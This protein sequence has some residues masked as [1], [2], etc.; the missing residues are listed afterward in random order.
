MVGA[1]VGVVALVAL[2][3]CGSDGATTS[4]TTGA[5]DRQA[6]STSTSSTPDETGTPGLP[7]DFV[8]AALFSAGDEVVA[9]APRGAGDPDADQGSED[10]GGAAAD[11][12]IVAYRSSDGETWSEEGVVSGLDL[13]G[14]EFV[15]GGAGDADTLVLVGADFVEASSSGPGGRAP[16][17]LTS[18]DGL[19]WERVADD[20]L[21]AVREL[22]AITVDVDSSGFLAVG[23]NPE[24]IPQLVATDD[25]DSWGAVDATGLEVADGSETVMALGASDDAYV[26]FGLSE[27]DGCSDDE[28]A[29][30]WRSDDGT[31]WAEVELGAMADALDEPNTDLFPA[32][33]GTSSGFVALVEASGSGVTTAWVS[34]DGSDWSEVA[35]D[36]PDGAELRGAA[37]LGDEALVLFAADGEPVLVSVDPTS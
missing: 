21:T 9:L 28:V 8:S 11:L 6:A 14:D 12:E 19:E 3:A 13:T 34:T 4:A 37:A 2:T 25:G 15:S 33:V 17:A 7:A 16:L 35:L 32:L 31:D 30:A 26:A 10:D 29:V 20:Q 27:C 18:P 5:D 24:A 23:E 36:L 22:S 1:L